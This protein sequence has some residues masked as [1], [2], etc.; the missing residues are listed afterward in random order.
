MT[1]IQTEG[2]HATGPEKQ[3][4]FTS[5]GLV[6]KGVEI[7]ER[8]H[9]RYH[10]HERHAF[11][12]WQCSRIVR[13]DFNITTAKMV[14][15]GKTSAG[16]FHQIGQM[17]LD[18]TAEADALENM[19]RKYE[20]PRHIPATSLELR[21]VSEQAHAVYAALVTV[22]RALS[23]LLHSEMAQVAEANC[24]AFF[25]SFG[26]LKGLVFGGRREG[27]RKTQSP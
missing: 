5:D 7:I 9:T 22:D 16:R 26:R 19:A 3:R 27:S 13:R 4:H 25:R 17:L 20:M 18:L 1:Q 6:I 21:I 2:T 11:H 15:Y 23:K 10:V 8:I 24:E 12:S 14:M